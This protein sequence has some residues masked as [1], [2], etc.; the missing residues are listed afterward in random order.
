MARHSIEN[1]KK[2][3]E[4]SP[5][6][7]IKFRGA[8]RYKESIHLAIPYSDP[9][10]KKDYYRN[11]YIFTAEARCYSQGDVPWIIL[12]EKNDRVDMKFKSL[13][14]IH[15][16]GTTSL[17]TISSIEESSPYRSIKIKAPDFFLEINSPG[18]LRISEEG[19]ALEPA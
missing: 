16:N 19:L 7:V 8:S 13:L 10:E 12:D 11:A 1:I 15:V 5:G 6:T 17:G 14:S 18:Q 9:V 3:Y 4:D 2:G